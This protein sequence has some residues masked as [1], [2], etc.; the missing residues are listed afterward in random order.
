MNRYLRQK[1]RL[2]IACWLLA[3]WNRRR[4]QV[5]LGFKCQKQPL[6][7]VS[8]KSTFQ[9]LHWVILLFSWSILGIVIVLYCMYGHRQ[10]RHVFGRARKC[11]VQ[12][13]PA[14][15]PTIP[16]NSLVAFWTR[17]QWHSSPLFVVGFLTLQ[18]WTICLMSC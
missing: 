4:V 6:L 3:S 14:A 2:T 1:S 11:V 16:E 18:I 15:P 13:Q 5:L 17:C 7:S 12:F 8:S 10:E 9:T